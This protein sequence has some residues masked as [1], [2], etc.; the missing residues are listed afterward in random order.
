MGNR[1]NKYE[2]VGTMLIE[3]RQHILLDKIKQFGSITLSEIAI[4]FNVSEETVRRD[5]I[6]LDKQGL[7]RKV[8]GGAVAVS[9]SI[10]EDSYIN[11][12]GTG[13]EQKSIIGKYSAGLINSNDTI[14]LDVGTTTDELAK[15]IYNVENITVVTNSISVLNILIDK[16]N[17]ADFTGRI[18]FL[19]GEVVTDQYYTTGANA[20]TLLENFWA[21]K[22]FISAT[23]LSKNGIYDYNITEACFSASILKRAS[24]NYCLVT[25]GKFN[26]NSLYRIAELTKLDNIITDG[27]NVIDRSLQECIADNDINLHITGEKHE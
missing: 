1:T 7:L 24:T 18:Y 17:N 6:T 10:V 21:D 4:E 8:R 15:N 26:T 5:I 23:S 14:F 9:K 11:R 16:R 19:G 27:Q 22:A 13:A 25:S 2:R 3:A 20:L 12:V